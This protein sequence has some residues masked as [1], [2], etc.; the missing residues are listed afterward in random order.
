M[1]P[2]LWDR[3]Q[4]LYYSALPVA[5]SERGEVVARI[6]DSDPILMQEVTSLLEADDS[7]A[8][9]LK[10]PVFEV[11]LKIISSN[12]PDKSAAASSVPN[13][14]LGVTI[15]GRYLVEKEI[16]HGGMGTVYLAR[17]Q[18]LHNKRTV[19]KVLLE[20]SLQNE[21][22]VQKFQQEKEA[23]ARVDHH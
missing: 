17:D 7:S 5:P 14:L 12:H 11:G 8:D 13:Q 3:I 6:C 20:K 21:W 16:G 19:V 10:S 22:V 4:E 1:E 9:F 18:R 15:D 23:L 2:T